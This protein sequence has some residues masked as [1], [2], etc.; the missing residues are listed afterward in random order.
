MCVEVRHVCRLCHTQYRTTYDR[1]ERYHNIIQERG[2][3]CL[4]ILTSLFN[5]APRHCGRLNRFDPDWDI[6]YRHNPTCSCGNDI[7]AAAHIRAKRALSAGR[8]TLQEQEG[9][10]QGPGHAPGQGQ[11]DPFRLAPRPSAGVGPNQGLR[12]QPYDGT[13]PP[14]LPTAPAPV[15][16]RHGSHG[17]HYQSNRSSSSTYGSKR[18]DPQPGPSPLM[19][20]PPNRPQRPCPNQSSGIINEWEDVPL[21]SPSP[22][23]SPRPHLDD[24]GCDNR[25]LE[26]KPKRA[27]TNYEHH[28][29]KYCSVNSST[30]TSSAPASSGLYASATLASDRRHQLLT[31][32]RPEFLRAGPN[33]T[34]VRTP[35]DAHKLALNEQGAVLLMPV[36]NVMEE[37]CRRPLA[38]H[39]RQPYGQGV[40]DN[41]DSMAAVARDDGGRGG[42]ER[43]KKD[44]TAAGPERKRRRWT[45]IGMAATRD[46][47]KCRVRSRSSSGGKASARVSERRDQARKSSKVLAV[48]SDMNRLAT[49]GG[50]ELLRALERMFGDVDDDAYAESDVSFACHTSRAVERGAPHPMPKTPR[51]PEWI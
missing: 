9:R 24:G 14:S 18:F 7:M 5:A 1:C 31:V 51:H 46:G 13:K 29:L 4:S 28:N 23:R 6:R 3:T 49:E 8:V 12:C 34:L 19:P 36:G 37:G 45:D 15:H 21:S 27:I 30:A 16:R 50:D 39:S 42:G 26:C 47:E 35:S 11:G 48:A 40:L 22:P 20:L 10:S 44:T 43:K 41:L 32:D 17:N 25:K 38:N 2:A 33:V